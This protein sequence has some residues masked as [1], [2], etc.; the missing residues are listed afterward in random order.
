VPDSVKADGSDTLRVR[1]IE[2]RSAVFATTNATREAV[3]WLPSGTEF[4]VR[5]ELSDDDV[6]VRIVPPEGVHVWV[7]RELIRDGKVI[8]DKSR[9]RTGAGLNFRPVG[10][11]NKG[12][13]VE[14]RGT[15]GD[16]LKI[17]PPRSLDFWVLRDQVEPLAEMPPEGVMAETEAE[18]AVGAEGMETNAAPVALVTAVATNL[19]PAVVPQS[20]TVQPLAVRAPPEL[21]GRMLAD[22]PD[23]GMRVRLTGLLDWGAVG[24]AAAPFCLVAR[25]PDGDS[26]PLCH[27][28]AAA[29]AAKPL[30]GVTVAVEGTSWRVK[31]AEL[32]VVIAET[33]RAIE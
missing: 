6:W 25:Q 17:R 4:A 27:L 31:G 12:E 26:R 1:V 8:A 28:I 16:W 23:Q 21:A 10:S 9:I 11:L 29:A 19:P 3:S 30:V 2:G 18:Q 7:Y 22:A 13:R 32:P 15:Y 5:G 33:L 20:L 24:T 14:V